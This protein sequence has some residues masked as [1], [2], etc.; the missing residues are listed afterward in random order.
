MS[1]SLW[2][3]DGYAKKDLLEFQKSLGMTLSDGLTFSLTWQEVTIILVHC[4]TSDKKGLILR[5]VREYSDGLMA[6]S[7]PHQVYQVG[8]DAVPEQDPHWDYT[9]AID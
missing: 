8:G 3:I 1:L 2:K 4:C 5:K 6:A 7:P 9:D